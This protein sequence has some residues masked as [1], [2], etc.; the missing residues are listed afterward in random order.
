[1]EAF[2]DLD[3]AQLGQVLQQLTSRFDTGELAI[4]EEEVTAKVAADRE[5]LLDL[6]A[7]RGLSPAGGG[8]AD[9]LLEVVTAIATQIPE[10]RPVVDDAARQAR[11]LGVLP[12]S[13]VAADILVIAAAG[14]ILRPRV[15]VKRS[16]KGD[17]RDLEVRIGAGGTKSLD[18]ILEVILRH[19]RPG[20]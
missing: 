6:A 10:T 1:M 19:L 5:F 15:T 17:D 4:T 16:K 7:L 8:R 13:D 11:R 2:D 9:S 12:I 18:T 3:E 20:G 14:A